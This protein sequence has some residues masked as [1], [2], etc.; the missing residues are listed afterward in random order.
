MKIKIEA[1][2]RLKATAPSTAVD[3]LEVPVQP[4]SCP[5]CGTAEYAS[6]ERRVNGYRICANRHKALTA[7]WTK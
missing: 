7:S 4:G 2:D 5:D 6:T 1:A 3:T